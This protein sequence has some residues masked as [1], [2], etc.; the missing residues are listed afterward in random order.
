MSTAVW[1]WKFGAIDWPG[2][3]WKIFQSQLWRGGAPRGGAALGGGGGVVVV[4]WVAP[5][6]GARS[7][8]RA[9]G[10]CGRGSTAVREAPGS[11]YPEEAAMGAMRRL[12][13][14]ERTAHRRS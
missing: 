11:E 8:T 1:K 2:A 14:G 4:V 13:P 6:S 7:C 10:T 9:P 3:E 12:S 5:Q